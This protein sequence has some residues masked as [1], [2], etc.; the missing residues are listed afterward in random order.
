MS[1][2]TTA[3]LTTALTTGILM[4]PSA[5]L[6]KTAVVDD[7][8][9]DVWAEV[10]HPETNSGGWELSA[11]SVNVDVVKTVVKHTSRRLAIT[12]T[13]DNLKKEAK[14]RPGYWSN[15]KL[16][17]GR[18]AAATAW[19]DEEAEP[20][21]HITM[22]T[23]PGG[24]WS[25]IR[26]C[27]NFTSRFHWADDTLTMSIPRSCYETPKFVRFH[28]TSVGAYTDPEPGHESD[29]FWDDA[30]D[31]GPDNLN[32]TRPWTDRLKAG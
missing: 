1:R 28:G 27:T 5:A 20:M 24:R 23:E 17:D 19:I 16:P 25:T 13:F 10:Y 21:Q 6:A 15:F 22:E 7:G 31:E 9:S 14:Y 30:H 3:A 29:W 18:Q 8:T 2:R 4:V 12:V 32:P 11:A 26:D